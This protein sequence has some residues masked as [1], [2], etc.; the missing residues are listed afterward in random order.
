MNGVIRGIGRKTKKLK[1]YNPSRLRARCEGGDI[2]RTGCAKLK[3]LILNASSILECCN[4][5]EITIYTT[6]HRW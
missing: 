2:I 5:S 4:M 6:S 1:R 3:M